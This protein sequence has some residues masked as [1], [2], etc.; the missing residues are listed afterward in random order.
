M[1]KKRLEKRQ[2]AYPKQAQY[3]ASTCGDNC[4]RFILELAKAKDV[5][6]N[7]CHIMDFDK[8]RLLVYEVEFKSGG[9]EYS[10]EINAA[11][12][13]ILKHETELDN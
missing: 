3:I 10:Y 1:R 9:M 11:T 12:G 13:A 7:L 8:A 2:A 5:T 4:A 6:I